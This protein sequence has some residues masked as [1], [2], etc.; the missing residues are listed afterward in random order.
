MKARYGISVVFV[1]SLRV[2]PVLA[3]VTCVLLLVVGPGRSPAAPA[4]RERVVSLAPSLT[5]IVCALGAVD[6]LVGRTSACDYPPALL[7]KVPVIGGFGAPSLELLLQQR[8]TIVIDVAL[9]DEALGRRMESL[10]LQRRRIP[11]RSLDDIP[12]AIR[13]V[14]GLLQREPVAEALAARLAAGVARCRRE[15][16]ARA[17]LRARPKVY[18]EIWSDPLMTCGRRTFVAELIALAGGKNIGDEIDRDY[19]PVAPEWILVRQPDV[20]LGL[21]MANAAT[22]PGQIRARSGWALIPAVQK[23][24]I[25]SG[26]DS[27][28]LLRPGPRAL[29]GVEVLRK[30]LE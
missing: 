29:D 24:R 12:A 2:T 16:A 23:G 26:L 15:A 20:M 10:G 6:Q 1:R 8:P 27:A 9:E 17:A 4:P 18:A 22:L 14:G 25:F 19:F 28:L 5:E 3:G 21:Y 30:C 7:K 11:C 13:T